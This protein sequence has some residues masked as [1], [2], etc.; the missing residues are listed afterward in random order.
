MTVHQAVFESSASQTLLCIQIT[1]RFKS[2]GSG[3]YIS[4]KPQVRLIFWALD[5]TLNN[6]ATGPKIKAWSLLQRRI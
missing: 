5:H 2:E 6:K 3:F 4:S 1:R